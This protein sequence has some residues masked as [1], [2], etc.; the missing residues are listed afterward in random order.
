M[1]YQAI[2][3]WLV[4]V[5]LLQSDLPRDDQRGERVVPAPLD[6][7]PM[8]SGAPLDYQYFT[9]PWQNLG[10]FLDYDGENVAPEISQGQSV[11]YSYYNN[12]KPLT[13][14]WAAE[15]RLQQRL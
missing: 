5:S 1:F 3:F 8:I 9:T 6:F 7:T 2:L 11:N 14:T 4:A 12:S 15:R 10:F 13:V